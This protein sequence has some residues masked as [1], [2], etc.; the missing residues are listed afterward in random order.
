MSQPPVALVTGAARGIGL[1]IAQSLI[2]AGYRVMAADLGAD[3]AWNYQLGQASD[4]AQAL[5][6]DSPLTDNTPLF[7]VCTVDVTNAAACEQAVQKT[8]ETFGQLNLLVNNAGIVDSGPITE[9]SEAAWDRIFAVNT[10]GIFLMSKAA[11]PHLLVADN[12]SIVNT[13]SIAGKKGVSNMAAYCGSKFAAIGITQSMA[14]E[15]AQDKIRVNA[16]CP[17]IV[18]TAMWLDHLIPKNNA[19]NSAPV[20]FETQTQQLIPMGVAQTA[21]DMADAVLYLA[22]AKNITGIALTVAGGMEMN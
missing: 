19:S 14:Q 13:A 5:Q 16:I 21:Q 4:I 3:Q 20:D 10:K 12:A 18:G 9:F 2:A 6:T 17:G 22:R 7:A 11:I 8:I 1:A 15:L